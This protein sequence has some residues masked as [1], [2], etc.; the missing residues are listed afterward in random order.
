VRLIE[1]IPSVS[2]SLRLPLFV[3]FIPFF[4]LLFPSCPGLHTFLFTFSFSLLL[5]RRWVSRFL[6]LGRRERRLFERGLV[7]STRLMAFRFQSISYL[8]YRWIDTFRSSSSIYTADSTRRFTE[9]R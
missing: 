4:V 2:A 3:F 7:S 8:R 9:R 5:V 6:S 1:V